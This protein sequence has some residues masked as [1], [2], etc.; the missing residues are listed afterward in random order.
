MLKQ[1]WKG[2]NCTGTH[3]TFTCILCKLAFYTLLIVPDSFDHYLNTILASV[4][5]FLFQCFI[6]LWASD[7]FSYSAFILCLHIADY[8]I[9]EIHISI[10]HN[11]LI[12]KKITHK[13]IRQPLAF[14]GQSS[15]LIQLAVCCSSLRLNH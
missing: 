15:W 7:C 1:D 14:I 12:I 8:L 3:R 11:L 2:A 13:T 10:F 5:V 9:C 4:F 6:C